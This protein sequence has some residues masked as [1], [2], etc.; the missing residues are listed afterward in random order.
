MQ[1]DRQR[2]KQ[3]FRAVSQRTGAMRKST[4]LE[5]VEYKFWTNWRELK[6]DNQ[7]HVGV[8][9]HQV[10]RMFD[11]KF[12]ISDYLLLTFYLLQILQ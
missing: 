5:T 11:S 9:H 12:G 10:H 6:V 1:S 3:L 2:D 7:M 4:V 8:F